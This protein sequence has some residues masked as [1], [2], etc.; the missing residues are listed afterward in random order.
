MNKKILFVTDSLSNGGAERQLALLVKYLPDG[1]DRRIWSLSEGPFRNVIENSNIRLD[2]CKR[3]WQFD[4]TPAFNLWRITREWSPDI[5]H[6][7]GWMS[8]LAAVPICK[9]MR[10]PLVN[11]SIRGGRLP[12]RR[13]SADTLSLKLS[14]GVIANSQAGLTAHGISPDKGVVIYN[15][16]DME[17]LKLA[18]QD[19][20]QSTDRFTV[21]MVGRM[22][23]QKD[24][25]SF[26]QAAYEMNKMGVPAHFM[27]VGDGSMRPELIKIGKE[28]V[29]KGYLSFPEVDMEVIPYLKCANVG[30]LMTNPE[31][32]AEGISNAIMEYM[33]CGLPVICNNLG[34][35]R[36]IVIE[37]ETGFIIPSFDVEQLV[38]KIIYLYKNPIL[39]KKMGKAGYVRLLSNFSTEKMVENMVSYYKNIL[40][41]T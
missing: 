33:A 1:W 23:L 9:A 25:I 18:E 19:V 29:N 16:F 36:E 28:L 30:V 4:I 2:V 32:A 7:W 38:E 27:I 15:G 8:A 20:D 22:T 11:G 41:M 34:G 21:I 13:S 14:D 40:R 12:P 24:F 26:I 31:Y 5:I 3:S 39:S 10:I 17:R 6:A 35:N 37:N